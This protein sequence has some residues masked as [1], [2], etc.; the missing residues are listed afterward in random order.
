MAFFLK[1][2]LF[3]LAVL[4]LAAS[5]IGI[6]F[7]N[8]AKDK[9][10]KEEGMQRNRNFLIFV[11]VASILLS[12]YGIYYLRPRKALLDKARAA[13][14][15]RFQKVASYLDGATKLTEQAA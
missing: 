11:L 5:A 3:I 14:A 15:A 10:S 12:F 9:L 1:V 4:T 8:K 13:G 2:I 6:Q 7:Y